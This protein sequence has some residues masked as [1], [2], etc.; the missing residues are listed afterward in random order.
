VDIRIA[1]TRTI[2]ADESRLRQLLENLIRNA[3]EHSSTSPPASRE[4]AVEHGSEDVTITVGALEDGFYVADD[5]VGI[6]E[7][8]REKVFESGYTTAEEG[9]GIGLGLVA[10]I[11]DAHGWE[12]RLTESESGGARFEFTGVDR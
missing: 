1:S 12:V 11:A 10:E 3:V 2:P 4:D 6:P 5:G 9:T 7:S 8:E